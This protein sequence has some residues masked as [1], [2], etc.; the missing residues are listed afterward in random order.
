M[1]KILPLEDSPIQTYQGETFILDILLAHDNVKNLCYNNYI[2]MISSTE[3]D[4]FKFANSLWYD[5]ENQGYA[6][7]DM[8]HFRQLEKVSIIGFLKDRIDKGNYIILYQVDEFYLSYSNKYMKLH[9]SHDTYIYGYG[10]DYFYVMAYSGRHLKK[11]MVPFAEMEQAIL[12]QMSMSGDEFSTF[13]VNPLA[14]IH[15]DKNAILSGMQMFIDCVGDNQ[16][17]L[18]GIAIYDS[19]VRYVEKFINYEGEE[20]MIFDLRF[21][22]AIWEHDI[23]MCKRIEKLS[24]SMNIDPSIITQAKEIESLSNMIFSMSI[25]IYILRDK[26]IMGKVKECIMDLKEKERA[27]VEEM[28]N[29]LSKSIE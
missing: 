26:Q 14:D 21:F 2:N 18:F 6:I 19:L 11:M 5:Y 8:F 9:F 7:M 24:T 17:D 1:E 13:R 22:R 12:S 28:I 4:M 27:L 20:R 10:D 23:M 29:V 25:K 16:C 3:K 15:I